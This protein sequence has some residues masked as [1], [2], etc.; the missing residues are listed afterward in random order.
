[1]LQVVDDKENGYAAEADTMAEFYRDVHKLRTRK[2]NP[3]AVNVV[4]FVGPPPMPSRCEKCEKPRTK[5]MF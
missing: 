3:I 1:M 5:S 2:K 4:E